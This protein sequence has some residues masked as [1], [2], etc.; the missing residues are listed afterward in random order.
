MTQRKLPVQYLLS[1]ILFCSFLP[2]TLYTQARFAGWQISRLDSIAMQ[3]VPAKAPGIATAIICNGELV[4][5][6]Y[7][8]FANLTDSTPIN[9]RTR[10]NIASNGKQ[11]TALAILTLADAGKLSPTDDIRRY[12][13][14]LYPRQQDPITIQHLLN[15]T[16]GIRDCY[17]LWSLQGYTWWKKSFSN[18]DVFKL[19]EKQED[20]NFPPG[21]KYLYSNTNYILLALLV[22]KISGKTFVEYTNAMFRKLNMPNT[23]FEDNYKSIS[24]PI[25]RAYFNFGTWTTFDWIWNVVGDGNIFSTLE[26]QVQWEKMLQGG[27]GIS[28]NPEIIRR[29]Q[30]PIEGSAFT[31]YGYGLEFGT[32]K[33]MPYSFHEG[34]T[35]AWKATTVRFPTKQTTMVTLTNT[36]KAIPSMQ[37]RQM[38]DVVFGL[39][40]DEAYLVTRPAKTGAYVSDDS[41]TGT[42]LTENDFA[43]RFEKKGGKIFFKR[44]GRNDVELE[45]EADNIFHQK[46]DPAFKQ[47]FTTTATGALQVTAYYVNHAPYSLTR[48]SAGFTGFDFKKLSGKYTNAETGTSITLQHKSN[49]E[50]S[51][52]LAGRENESTGLMVATNKMLAD[53]YVL[54]FDGG[55]G[56]GPVLFLDGE[57]IKRVKFER[58]VD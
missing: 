35:G 57:R 16:S 15:H 22:E 10:F 4:Y 43:F 5:E 44:V 52:Q 1:L 37:T 17:D 51:V 55:P 21:T 56:N 49:M 12:F 38:A 54:N 6:K 28:L 11:F 42:Y 34:A 18:E 27:A 20:L 3:D 47:E 23:S 48:Q 45:R 53:N 58:V 30:Q 31:N 39:Q 36:G 32:Y 40:T 46:F 50:Y 19:V 2:S 8:G 41:I 33:H 25:A 7:G 9:S 13:P 26:D 24:G 14:T 29:S